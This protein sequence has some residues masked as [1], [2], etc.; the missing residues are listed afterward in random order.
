MRDAIVYFMIEGMV[1]ALF[2]LTIR[3]F[4]N[5]GWIFASRLIGIALSLYLWANLSAV[6]AWMLAVLLGI[7]LLVVEG[8]ALASLAWRVR[9]E[10]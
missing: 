1:K 6:S 2:A 10:I 3:P 9:R 5:W 7:L 8:A 4:P